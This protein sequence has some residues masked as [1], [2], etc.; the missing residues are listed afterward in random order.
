[1]KYAQLNSLVMDLLHDAKDKQ[2]GDEKFVDDIVLMDK[3]KELVRPELARFYVNGDGLAEAVFKLRD[4]L[5]GKNAA[6][7]KKI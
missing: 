4:E 6:P 1:M 2:P 3:E 5:R 7:K